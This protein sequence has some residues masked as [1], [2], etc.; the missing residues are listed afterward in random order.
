MKKIALSIFL[1]LILGAC[2][3]TNTALKNEHF[4]HASKEVSK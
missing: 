4:I 2:N 3:S 1:L